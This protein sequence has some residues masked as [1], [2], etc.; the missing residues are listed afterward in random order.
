MS[1]WAFIQ[2]VAPRCLCL[3]WG[4]TLSFQIMLASNI[5]KLLPSPF[6]VNRAASI[7]VPLP[8]GHTAMQAQCMLQSGAG[9]LVALC[10]AR[11]FFPKVLKAKQGNSISHASSFC[12]DSTGYRIPIY[13]VLSEHSTIYQWT[14]DAVNARQS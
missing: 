4:S 3:V 8:F 10:F 2:H 5:V 9:H 11:I 13:C 1:L 6:L 7:S 14:T 12:Y